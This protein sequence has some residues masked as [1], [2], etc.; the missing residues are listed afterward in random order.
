M[1]LILGLALIA[2]ACTGAAPRSDQS[3][4]ITADGRAIDGDTVSID[5]RLFG[6][7]IS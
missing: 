2:A 4:A 6:K 5:I 3:S 1:R 7:F